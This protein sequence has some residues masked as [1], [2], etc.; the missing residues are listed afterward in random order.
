MTKIAL[1][2][3]LFNLIS[4]GYHPNLMKD[5]LILIS[6]KRHTLPLQVKKKTERKL[7][8]LLYS[9]TK[10]W[11]HT[12]AIAEAKKMFAVLAN[13]HQWT[14][15]ISEDSV[16]FNPGTL[17]TYDVVIWL[18]VT[19]RTLSDQQRQAFKNFLMDGGG[20]VGIHGSGD[21][22]HQWDW[23]RDEVIRATFSHHPMHPQF[24]TAI[25]ERE[26]HTTSM[27]CSDLPIQWRWED[28]WYVFK[29]S[30]R[31]KGVNVIY[32]LNERGL[33][34]SQEEQTLATSEHPGKGNDHPVIW[35]HTV[36]KGK[37]FYSALGHKG[38]YY[39]NENHQ[40]LLVEAVKWTGNL[41]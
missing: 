23:Y 10:A 36:G 8:I 29:E 9:K 14:L 24:Q 39:K 41:N 11:R 38:S 31:I 18:N 4:Y 6:G 1:C 32:T 7:N 12:E 13:R 35:N 5:P 26:C 16:L 19:G 34:L 17:K 25:L 40:K 15:T 30:P 22:S 3:L 37:V 21:G 28:E 33:N 20:F 2:L 27:D